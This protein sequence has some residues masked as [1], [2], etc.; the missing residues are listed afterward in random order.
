MVSSFLTECKQ[1]TD[2]YNPPKVFL[3]CHRT[4]M[5]KGKQVRFPGGFLESKPV[6]YSWLPLRWYREQIIRGKMEVE[7]HYLATIMIN[8]KY[9]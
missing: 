6:C 9:P 3:N 7:E 5:G 1:L 8:L 2:F 4:P